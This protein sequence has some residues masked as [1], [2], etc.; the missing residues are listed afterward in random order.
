MR[1]GKCLQW[2]LVVHQH[3]TRRAAMEDFLKL[4]QVQHLIGGLWDSAH[5]RTHNY[6]LL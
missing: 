3:V 4:A 2:K 6:D 5:K 1:R